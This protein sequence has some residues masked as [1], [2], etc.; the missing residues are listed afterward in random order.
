MTRVLRERVIVK[1]VGAV[2]MDESA[3]VCGVFSSISRFET[4]EKKEKDEQSQ[5]VLPRPREIFDVNF[6]VGSRSPLTP[7]EK[8]FFG[9]RTFLAVGGKGIRKLD[10][11]L[12]FRLNGWRRREPGEENRAYLMSAIENRRT[13][14]QIM[15]RISLR[16]LSTMSAVEKRVRRYRSVMECGLFVDSNGKDEKEI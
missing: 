5:S 1:K 7:E 10:T 6:V 9:V 14:D 2:A 4:G 3:A 15:P 13:S 8:T 16:L 12:A 11:G